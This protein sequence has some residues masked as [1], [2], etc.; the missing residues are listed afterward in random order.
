[1]EVAALF[2]ETDGAYFGVPGVQ[3]GM[4]HGT[5]G[6]T[7]VRIQSW[8]IHPASGGADTGMA[9]RTSSPVPPG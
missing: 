8:R 2:V 7:A 9:R 5:P 1:M 4:S 3:P 6:P